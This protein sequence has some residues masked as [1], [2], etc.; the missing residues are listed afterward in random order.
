MT[1]V[2]LGTT[3]LSRLSWGQPNP[4]VRIIHIVCDPIY[5]EGESTRIG[6]TWL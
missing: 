5:A 3:Q 6:L 1:P 2:Y 4:N